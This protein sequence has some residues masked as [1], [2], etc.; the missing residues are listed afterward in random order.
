MQL[1]MWF[2]PPCGDDSHVHTPLPRAGSHNAT[3]GGAAADLALAVLPPLIDGKV[4]DATAPPFRADPTGNTDATAALT[5]AL[6]AAGEGGT[7]TVASG[8][9]ALESP[10]PTASPACKNN[11]AAICLPAGLRVTLA[12]AGRSNTVVSVGPKFRKQAK[13][14]FA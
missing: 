9:Y 1:L 11:A 13:A 14:T 2:D 7:A 12:G 10:L 8:A 4:V 6:I 3:T 5:A